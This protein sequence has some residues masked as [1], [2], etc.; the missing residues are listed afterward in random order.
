MDISQINN[1]LTSKNIILYFFKTIALIISIFYLIYSVVIL[2]QTEIM[3]KTLQAK[4]YFLIYSISLFQVF[5]GVF[6]L[7][8]TIFFL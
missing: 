4:N 5:L 3:N 1:L 2:K 8:L 7:L 6:L